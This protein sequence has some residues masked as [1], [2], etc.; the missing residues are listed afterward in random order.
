MRQLCDI[1]V[2]LALVAE[3]HVHH[4]RCAAWWSKRDPASPLLI[5]REVQSSLLRLLCTKAVMGPEVHTLPQAWSVYASLLQCGGFARVLE[6]RGVD[7]VWERLCR[8]FRQAPKVV[9]DAYLAAFAIT[10]LFTL[11]TLDAA[12]SKFE[13]LSLL[14][15]PEPASPPKARIGERVNV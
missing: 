1:N 6:P 14:I 12:F 5:C 8:P 15:P 7:V 4:T 3:R 10:G 9:T 2:L 11:V 13:G